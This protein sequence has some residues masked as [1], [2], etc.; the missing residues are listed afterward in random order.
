M[1]T[2]PVFAPE[3]LLPSSKE[4]A[5]ASGHKHFFSGEICPKGHNAPRFDSDNSCTECRRLPDVQSR[6][7]LRSKRW[8]AEN[9]ERANEDRRK[10]HAENAE[11]AKQTVRAWYD[12]NLDRKRIIR[13]R[14][15]AAKFGSIE[16]YSFEELK[17]LW[18]SIPHQCACCAIPITIK[19]RHI[20]HINPLARG[21]SNAITNIQFLCS[22][23]NKSKG[24]R[25]PID[26]MR[27]NG[28]LL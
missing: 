14:R 12:N 2:Q 27:A 13:K 17:N 4:E 26:F 6:S 15:R 10:W 3:G 24:A 22:R 1:L 19:S 5:K 23:C 11:R 8:H 20:D 9:R 16:H 18:D 28:R 25:D 21:G 7:R